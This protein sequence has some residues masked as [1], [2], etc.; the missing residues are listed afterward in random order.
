M[1]NTFECPCK[2][3]I[4]GTDFTLNSEYV[5][6][7]LNNSYQVHGNPTVFTRVRVQRDSQT[8]KKMKERQARGPI[9]QTYKHFSNMLKT[10]KK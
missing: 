10:V 7:N 6:I 1:R 5:I 8:D 2:V 4:N 3:V 9:N